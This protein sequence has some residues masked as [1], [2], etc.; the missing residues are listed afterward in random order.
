MAVSY[1]LKDG[2]REVQRPWSD[3]AAT[4]QFVVLELLFAA[5]H[6]GLV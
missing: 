4:G 1:R 3:G 2:P 6:I 5:M